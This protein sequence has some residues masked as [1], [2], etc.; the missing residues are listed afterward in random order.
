MIGCL[1]V[2]SCTTLPQ[3]VQT[4]SSAN[5]RNLASSSGLG[6]DDLPKITSLTDAQKKGI[7][8]LVTKRIAQDKKHLIS[9]YSEK[10]S[11]YISYMNAPESFKPSMLFGGSTQFI[12]C[13]DF[14]DWAC[15]EKTPNLM[16]TSKYRQDTEATL[17]DRVDVNE[18]FRMSWWFTEAWFNPNRHASD[19]LA[20][21]L[22][23]IIESQKWKTIYMATYGFDQINASMKP[24]YDSLKNQLEQ[25]ADIQAVFDIKNIL[26][27][28]NRPL[29]FTHVIPAGS[30][31]GTIFGTNSN[32]TQNRNLEFQYR[33]TFEMLKLLN[34]N[35]TNDENSK[36]RLE[37][38]NNGIMHNK[39]IIFEKNNLMSLWTGTANLSAT[40]MGSENNSNMGIYIEND[41]IARV[42]H[43][44]F[45]EMYTLNHFTETSEKIT[46]PN[47]RLRVGKFHTNKRPDTRRYFKFADGNEVRIHFSPTDDAEHRVILPMI[48]SAKAGDEIRI[49][50]FGFGGIE[51]ERALQ[52][53]AARGAKL[54][55]V[56]DNVTT[57]SWRK[58]NYP[59]FRNNPYTDNETP[60]FEFRIENWSKWN[61]MKIATLTRRNGLAEV[62]T[63][64]SQ[65]WSS[66]GNNKNDENVVTVRNLTRDVPAAVAFNKFFDD[67]IWTRSMPIDEFITRKTNE[68]NPSENDD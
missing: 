15:L 37:W 56:F 54:K 68:G 42:F 57:G 8:D 62:I 45:N 39:F 11:N 50:M 26:F 18:P 51:L 36:A 63:V 53:A 23:N 38:K 7:T 61:H 28:D 12:L 34:G 31:N 52:M 19:M 65:N 29:V 25:G 49:A 17:G 16:P 33:D 32:S 59:A 43:K 64:G 66:S 30:G 60:N 67:N 41:A 2:T 58:N 9:E 13:D 20:V 55:V 6:S 48:L 40:C 3:T 27:P 47:G 35:S 22:A 10:I 4:N 44:E 1:S 46:G 24:V 21:K 14:N 5:L